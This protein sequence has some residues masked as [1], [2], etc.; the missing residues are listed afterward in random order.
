MYRQGTS[1]VVG[2]DAVARA[3]KVASEIV[4]W[5]PLKGDVAGS[6]DLGYAYGSYEVK[7]TSTQPA[8]RGNYARV[9]RRKSGDWRVVFQVVSPTPPPGP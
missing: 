5:E 4:V 3:L 7:A 9:W 6:G 8:Q 2:R 1:P